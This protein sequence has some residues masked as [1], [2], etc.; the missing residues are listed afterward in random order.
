ME[1]GEFINLQTSGPFS[2]LWERWVIQRR[3]GE[4]ERERS[5]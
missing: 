4:R 3:G 2:F 1:R 5:V